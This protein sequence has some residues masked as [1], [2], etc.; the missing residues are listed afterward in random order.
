MH[1]AQQK[2]RASPSREVRQA[3]PG[4]TRR[5]SGN[6]TSEQSPAT[7]RDLREGHGVG[8]EAGLGRCT[9][10]FRLR[11][12]V[13][14][15]A[16][17]DSTLCS[18]QGHGTSHLR[19]RPES[20]RSRPLRR[21]RERLA[22]SGLGVVI[23]ARACLIHYRG[24]VYDRRPSRRRI[25]TWRPGALISVK[26]LSPAVRIQATG[27]RVPG[28]PRQTARVAT[29][30]L[31]G[32]LCKFGRLAFNASPLSFLVRLDRRAPFGTGPLLHTGTRAR[33]RSLYAA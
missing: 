17:A 10:V 25:P 31:R 28:V 4:D 3:A 24:H 32:V 2:Q 30:R 27:Q 16:G 20:A 1:P 15:R 5:R 22:E 11:R 13:R 9:H 7:R 6:R 26:L 14:P 19:H 33:A 8:S 21:V 18:S 29:R 12:K 23:W